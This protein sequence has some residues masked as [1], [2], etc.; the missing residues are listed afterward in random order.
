MKRIFYLF[1]VRQFD[2]AQNVK[3]SVDVI[4]K[5]FTIIVGKATINVIKEIV[6]KKEEED[7]YIYCRR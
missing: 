2:F 1:F 3:V 7:D 4:F 5:G 6:A